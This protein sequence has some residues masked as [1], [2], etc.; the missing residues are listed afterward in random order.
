MK[1]QSKIRVDGQLDM[2]EK[3]ASPSTPIGSISIPCTLS[4]LTNIELMFRV[5]SDSRFNPSENKK[6]RKPVLLIVFNTANQELIN[7]THI[8][9]NSYAIL[10]NYFT[11]LVVTSA[12]LQGERDIYNR[13]ASRRMGKYGNKAGPNF[14]F[15]KTLNTAS[16]YGGY[17]LQIE[18]DC[19][20]SSSGWLDRSNHLVKRSVGTW[21]IGSKYAGSFGL[22]VSVL[23]HLNGN[24]LYEV[25]NPNFVK[26]LNEIWIPRIIQL[27]DVAPYLAYDCWWAYEM[28]SADSLRGNYSWQ[29]I[30]TYDSFFKNEPF[31]VN[32]L[33][34]ESTAFRFLEMYNLFDGLDKTPIFFHSSSVR[35]LFEKTLENT[36]STLLEIL[37]DEAREQV[38]T[39]IP[40]A[41]LAN[42][43][44]D[45]VDSSA[46][47]ATRMARIV[48][49]FYKKLGR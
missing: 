9:Y 15:Q 32:L 29:L 47:I 16:V 28:N 46:N 26:F 5:W 37:E 42:K 48:K 25:G 12:D 13:D 2:D 40:S 39:Q 24:G 4:D 17:T 27:A 6:F 14:L 22:D 23:N 1:H 36:K 41:T 21:V 38:E 33:P 3:T 45:I 18:L 30:Q 49:D 19:F 31:V 34:V 7:K 10:R 11:R 8:L 35:P 44:Y 43:Q 20:P